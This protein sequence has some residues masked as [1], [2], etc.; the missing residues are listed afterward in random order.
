[1]SRLPESCWI[2]ASM[3]MP[4]VSRFPHMTRLCEQ[5]VRTGDTA[6]APLY[7]AKA[8]ARNWRQK[9]V[10]RLAMSCRLSATR[11]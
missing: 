4:H 11:A 2:D 9:A 5:S 10:S 8:S 7:S 3:P 6:A 1:M